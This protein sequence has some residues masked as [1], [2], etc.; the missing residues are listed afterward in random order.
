MSYPVQQ[1][2]VVASPPP[3]PTGRPGV[4]TAAAV[5]LWV[6]ATTGLIYAIGTLVIVGGTVRRFQDV[7]TGDEPELYVGVVW[8]GA[9]VA[10]ALAVI[11]FALY[12]VL[13]IALRRGSNAARITTLVVSVLG[14][15]TGAGTALIVAAQRSGDT[16]PGSVGARLSDAYPSGWIP[17]N[18]GLAVAQ[19]VGYLLVAA[20]VLAAPRAFFGRSAP[21]TPGQQA[22]PTFPYA[23]AGDPA[24]APL[25]G[26]PAYGA[27]Y[28]GSA[29]GQGAPASATPSGAG[30]PAPGY[31]ASPGP[32]YGPP[33]AEGH[34][35]ADFDPS[36]SQGY[37]GPGY[38]PSGQGDAGSS[39]GYPP[40][41]VY[42]PPHGSAYPAAGSPYA[43]AGNPAG[44]TPSPY[45]RPVAQPSEAVIAPPAPSD[46][47]PPHA[48][49]P[50][51]GPSVSSVS[52]PPST[53]H[54]T[55]ASSESMP[56]IP[57]PG[58]VA[59]SSPAEGGSVS[60]VSSASAS[61]LASATSG[62]VSASPAA[63]KASGVASAS[64]SATEKASAGGI[65]AN[66]LSSP[67]SPAA[68]VERAAA[69]AVEPP[70]RPAARP[71]DEYWSRPSE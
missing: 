64:P 65:D 7:A 8:L 44:S 6:M 40:P 1:Q 52:P 9:A 54:S 67:G 46:A 10:L 60:S 13:G 70:K 3:A 28:P 25:S 11:L 12:V 29:Y 62:A 22:Q 36:P 19:V 16:V 18:V 15:L 57:G 17:T 50:A 71:D 66:Q 39:Q 2:P 20:L 53:Q 55:P 51:D 33:P 38:G 58:P 42:G 35:T 4:V 26:P 59:E 32:G 37:P 23:A 27:P 68:T 5:V 48:S 69:D 31:A 21:A 41:P 63:E 56:T 61:G 49:S 47:T 45:A 30:Y 34:S 24:S 43:T 14:V